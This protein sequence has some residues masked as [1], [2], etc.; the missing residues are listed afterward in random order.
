MDVNLDQVEVRDNAA[1]Q[2]YEAHAAGHTAIIEYERA[3][4]RITLI[5]T[6]VPRELEGHGL[7]ARMA[8]FALDDARAQGLTVIPSC[9]YIQSYIRRHQEYADLVP[10]ERREKLLRG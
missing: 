4:D 8:K 5:H 2:Q 6:E 9:P 7:A 3:G 1:A 10:P